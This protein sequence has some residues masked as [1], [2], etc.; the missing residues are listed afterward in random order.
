MNEER[1]L[2]VTEARFAL[3]ILTCLLVAIGYIALLRLGGTKDPTADQSSDDSSVP[4]ITGPATLPQS[5]KLEPSPIV[6]PLQNPADD[7]NE[8]AT[9]PNSG[10]QSPEPA[11]R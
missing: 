5:A 3:T 2:G 8:L 9:R 7:R 10:Q 1:N 11:R 6:L 4:S